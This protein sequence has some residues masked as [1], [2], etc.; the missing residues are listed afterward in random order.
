MLG[1][2]SIV[3]LL[4]CSTSPQW[5]RVYS[6]REVRNAVPPSKVELIQGRPT[7]PFREIA[8]VESSRAKKLDPDITS[9]MLQEIRERAA[10]LGADAVVDVRRLADRHEGFVDNPRTPFPSVMQGQWK[11]Y[12]FRGIA[13]RY[14]K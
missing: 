6:P 10:A 5:T 8:V 2:A 9:R 3:L 12:F 1:T 14:Q 4:G 11:T 13:V 7:R